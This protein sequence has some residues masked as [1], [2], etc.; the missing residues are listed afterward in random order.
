MKASEVER[1]RL[2][3]PLRKVIFRSFD[4]RCGACERRGRPGNPLEIA[5][6]TNFPDT[7]AEATDGLTLAGPIP[8]KTRA[9]IEKV[10]NHG[11]HQVG[12]MV[13]LHRETCHRPFDLLR[14][15]DVQAYRQRKQQLAHLQRQAACRSA[16]NGVYLRFIRHELRLAFSTHLLSYMWV[17]ETLH[18]VSLAYRAGDLDIPSTMIVHPRSR[19]FR[20]ARFRVSIEDGSIRQ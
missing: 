10:V 12:N 3:T 5:H 1:W 2:P 16:R 8:A 20:N 14:F 7:F 11:F 15:V 6:L 9:A 17:V 19:R 4:H 13:P 18:H